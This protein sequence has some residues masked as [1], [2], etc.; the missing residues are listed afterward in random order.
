MK[1]ELRELWG[2]YKT[3]F[4]FVIRFLLPYAIKRFTV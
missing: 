2:R 1:R 3:T 4:D